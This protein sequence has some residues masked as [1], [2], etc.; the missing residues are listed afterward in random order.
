MMDDLAIVIPA[1]K[2]RFFDITLKSLAEQTNKNFNVYIG[3]D[4]SPE[5]LN[6]IVRKFESRL[7]IKYYK[8]PDN[9]GAKNLINQWNR[10]IDLTDNE[11]WLWL[12]SDDDIA[13]SNCVETFF[14]TLSKVDKHF[15]VYRFNTRVINDD[16]NV[17]AEIQDSPL[18]ESSFDMAVALLKRKRGNSMPDHIFSR[19]VYKTYGGFVFTDFAQGADWATSILFSST[20]GIYSMKNAKIN[21]RLGS[22][23]IS[24]S[25][26]R[27]KDKM[28]NGHLQFLNWTLNH[29]HYLKTENNEK[30]K[31]VV[32]GVYENLNSVIQSH[33][34]GYSFKNIYGLS[35]LLKRLGRGRFDRIFDLIKLSY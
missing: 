25:A 30:Y 9:I 34:K 2:K 1:Y 6:K 11:K 14:E 12:F 31:Q 7:K 10:C 35:R 15:D 23:N 20:N 32:E 24:G 4:N 27:S 8:F 33:Y 17:I 22:S 5:D 16:G 26:K 21:W 18:I 3:D 13:D 29:F 19:E 28:I